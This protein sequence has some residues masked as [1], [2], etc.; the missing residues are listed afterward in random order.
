MQA[1]SNRWLVLGALLLWIG[2]WLMSQDNEVTVGQAP[3]IEFPRYLTEEE[4]KRL[5]SRRMLPEQLPEQVRD[6]EDDEEPLD[7]LLRAFGAGDNTSIIVF[8]ANAIRHS[9]LMKGFLDCL[10]KK[11]QDGLSKVRDELGINPL[12][13]ID[14]IALG[15]KIV[16]FSGHFENFQWDEIFKSEPDSYGNNT[17]VFTESH[18][19]ANS[20]E[21]VTERFALWNNEILIVGKNRKEIEE[22]I[23][24]L[25]G[26][27]PMNSIPLRESDT[28]G[29]AY[30]NMSTAMLGR[31]IPPEAGEL[32]EQILEIVS[33]V[34]VNSNAMSDVAIFAQ[35]S[36]DGNI[37]GLSDL[38]RSM[39]GALSMALAAA[40]IQGDDELARLL[41]FA[42]ITD[43][44][45]EL[46][47]E[48]ALPEAY[49]KQHLDK[50]CSNILNSPDPEYLEDVDDYDEDDYDEDDY[51]EDDYDE[52]DYDEDDYDEDDYD[53]DDYDEDDYDE[54]DY[55][56]DDYD[57]DE[58]EETPDGCPRCPPP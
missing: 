42:K 36:S 18:M 9:T 32:R 3:Q 27:I 10:G 48:I 23:D 26:R 39:G 15:D 56:E 2:A 54:D 34:K 24:T 5:D 38:G 49:L 40:R 6:D 21:R 11:A 22:T 13:D 33:G 44:H 58:D 50:V 46:S 14:R 35:L 17:Q 12:E 8:E 47:I 45:G 29:E 41:E 37:E 1:R 31:L 51:D 25:E 19:T 53:E 4:E 43:H 57:E 7:P 30:G 28:Y 55:D 16:M 20:D 52:D